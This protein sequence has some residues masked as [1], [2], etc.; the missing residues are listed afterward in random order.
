[1]AYRIRGLDP[2]PFTKF[3]HM[4]EAELAAAGVTRMRV[5]TS[6]GYPDRITMRDMEVGDTALLLNFEHLP[7]NSPYR[8]C[9]AIFVQEGAKTPADYRDTVPDVMTR[10]VMSLRGLDDRGFIVDADLAEGDDIEPLILKL[11]EDPAIAYIHAHY[12]KR[13][14]F[15]GLIERA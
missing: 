10:R 7:V 8:S 4:E 11:F 6:P 9:H 12:A 15:S 3:Y 1:M 2:T 14:C 5:D 13:G